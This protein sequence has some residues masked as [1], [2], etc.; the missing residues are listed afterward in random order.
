[1]RY[2]GPRMLYRH[3]LL[4]LRHRIDALQRSLCVLGSRGRK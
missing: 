2:A 1:M 4:A 3:P